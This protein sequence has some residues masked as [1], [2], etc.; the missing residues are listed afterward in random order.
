MF[1]VKPNQRI[2]C[3]LLT[4]YA[5][6]DGHILGMIRSIGGRG[7]PVYVIVVED[8]GKVASVYSKSRYCHGTYSLKEDL[9]SEALFHEILRWHKSQGLDRQS[10]LIPMTDKICTLVGGQRLNY[11]KYFKLCMPDNDVM[12]SMLDKKKANKIASEHG[13]SV[14]EY[15]KIITL[16][17]L[18]DVSDDYQMSVVVKP[19]WWK[20]QGEEYFKAGICE[21]RQKFL[22]IAE[23][24]IRGGAKILVQEYIPGNDQTVEVYMF[25]RSKNGETIHGCTGRKIRQVPPGVGSMAAGKAERLAHVA[26]MSNDFLKKIDYRGL[27]GIEYKRYQNKNYFIEMS[28]RPEGFHQLSIKACLNLPWLAYQDMA[29]NNMPRDEIKQC[30]AYYLKGS[31]YITLWRKYRKKVPVVRELTGLLLTGKTVFNLWSWRDPKPWLAVMGLYI[32]KFFSNI[33]KRL[34]S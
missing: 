19:I 15:M 11:E 29:L 31:A 9:G 24:L 12:Y 7:V 10:L 20:D 16:D 25:Y 8:N 26:G 21:T 2:P 4:S 34:L 22:E 17:Q 30:D 5:R 6:P 33:R 23:R 18:N 27:G 13:L 32:K 14:P 28:V 3:I 1:K